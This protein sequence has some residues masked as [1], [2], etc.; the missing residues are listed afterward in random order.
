MKKKRK[1][2]KNFCNKKT[3]TIEI[4]FLIVGERKKK[5]NN[6]MFLV[7]SALILILHHTADV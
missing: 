5:T 4:E 6:I 1:K 7:K 2:I 3:T